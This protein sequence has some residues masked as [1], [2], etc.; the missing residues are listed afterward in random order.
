M[1]S[2]RVSTIQSQLSKPNPDRNI[3]KTSWS[4]LKGLGAVGSLTA[5]VET[6][7][8]IIEQMFGS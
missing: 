1:V 6:V 7:K 2:Y 8:P 3:I 4:V 5:F